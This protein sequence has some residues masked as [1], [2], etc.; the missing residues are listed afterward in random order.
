MSID[1][2][3]HPHRFGRIMEDLIT[4]HDTPVVIDAVGITDHILI[5]MECHIAYA[6]P[7]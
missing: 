7:D 1:L 6:D 2:C 4:N 5:F 3:C